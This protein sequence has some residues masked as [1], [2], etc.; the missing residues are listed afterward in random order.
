MKIKCSRCG[1]QKGQRQCF[2]M[3]PA[4]PIC[5]LCCVEMRGAE[6]TGCEHY[7]VA[8]AY[9]HERR[10]GEHPPK[11]AE[12]HFIA[13]LNPEVERAV[14][15]ALDLAQTGAR[16]EARKLI[17]GL[18]REHPGNHVVYFAMGVLHALEE[19]P[20]EAI[21]C[22]DKAIDIF[23]YFV[24]AHFNRAV[25]YQTKLDIK[26][27]IRA[28]RKVV[29]IGDPGVPEVQDARAAVEEMEKFVRESDGIDLDTYLEALD[30]FDRAFARLQAGDYRSALAGFRSAAAKND[31][32][33]PTHGNLGLCLAKLGRKA[34]AQAEL[35]RA[36]ELDPGYHPARA[37]LLAVE[38]MEEGMPLSAEED[39]PINFNRDRLEQVE[40]DE[41]GQGPSFFDW[42]AEKWAQRDKRS[43]R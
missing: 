24:E 8:Q 13:E 29:E 43:R 2:R 11:S 28:F 23:P 19:K 1:K 10:A 25:A 32:N 38:L 34:E 17:D 40:Q 21:A 16:D 42:M 14:N 7:A 31:R 20:D 26:N 18:H 3:T 36:I 41:N 37:N 12:K 27:A 39:V 15:K 30:K 33:A 22:F 35:N 4:D 5:S 9:R 6:C